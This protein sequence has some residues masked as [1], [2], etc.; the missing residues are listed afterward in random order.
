MHNF[1]SLSW[2]YFHTDSNWTAPQPYKTYC[3]K[4]TFYSHFTNWDVWQRMCRIFSTCLSPCTLLKWP[5]VPTEMLWFNI[6]IEII[7]IVSA[8]RCKLIFPLVWGIKLRVLKANTISHE[9]TSCGTYVGP[10]KHL[11]L[12]FRKNFLG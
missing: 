4:S 8:T 10:C 7:F 2:N 5:H 3:V 9:G 11:P 1:H 12:V 6:V